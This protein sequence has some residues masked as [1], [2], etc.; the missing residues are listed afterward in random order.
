M[1]AASSLLAGGSA[2]CTP[3]CGRG[4]T[5]FNN[6]LPLFCFLSRPLPPPPPHRPLADHEPRPEAAVPAGLQRRA[7]PDREEL[8]HR[9]SLRQLRV[10]GVG[11]QQLQLRR[12]QLRLRPGAGTVVDET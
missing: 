11:L 7:E 2:H 1:P 3:L 9:D 4:N 8:G 10:L 6:L 12:F 5:T